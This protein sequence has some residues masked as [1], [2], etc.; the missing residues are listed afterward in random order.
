MEQEAG[1]LKIGARYKRHRHDRR[2]YRMCCVIAQTERG[3]LIDCGNGRKEEITEAETEK[4][5]E[6]R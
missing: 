4:M 2:A 6:V 1:M 5:E 3:W